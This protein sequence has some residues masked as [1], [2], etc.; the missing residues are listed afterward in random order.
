[1][2]CKGP[3]CLERSLVVQHTVPQYRCRSCGYSK[4]AL[5]RER[6]LPLGRVGERWAGVDLLVGQLRAHSSISG[7]RESSRGQTGV[8]RS[9]EVSVSCRPRDV[10]VKIVCGD[11]VVSFD[12]FV[13]FDGTT[14][15]L[16][17]V[18]AKSI[19][20]THNSTVHTIHKKSTAYRSQS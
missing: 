15:V 2:Q 4:A 7:T 16:A 17:T 18:F 14:V 12:R 11:C 20:F 6:G 3:L 5:S 13:K 8:G 9:R 10:I 19:P 1:M